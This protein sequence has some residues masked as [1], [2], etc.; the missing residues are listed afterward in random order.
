[1]VIDSISSSISCAVLISSRVAA[2]GLLVVAVVLDSGQLRVVLLSGLDS[3][4]G[5]ELASDA[6]T[7][8]DLYIPGLLI[9]Y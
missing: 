9:E 5:S 4:S 7:A 6:E 3:N 2:A 1:M 8:S